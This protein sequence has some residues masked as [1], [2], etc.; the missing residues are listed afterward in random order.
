M[1]NDEPKIEKG[2]PI[3]AS[4]RTGRSDLIRQMKIGDSIFFKGAE[5]SNIASQG[6]HCLGLGGSRTMA[7]KDGVRIWRIK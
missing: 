5:R 3:P 7:E 1:K 4:K 6:T 2:V